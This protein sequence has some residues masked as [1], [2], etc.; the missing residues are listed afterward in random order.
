MRSGSKSVFEARRRGN[1]FGRYVRQLLQ[2]AIAAEQNGPAPGV[3]LDLNRHPD[4]PGR[5]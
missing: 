5:P 4:P 1:T 2:E 3:R